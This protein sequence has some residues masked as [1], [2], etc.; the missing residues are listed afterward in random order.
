MPPIER[1]DVAIVGAGASGLAAAAALRRRGVDPVI[2][3]GDDRI[4]GTWARRYDRL[5]LHTAR[6]FSALPYHPLPRELPRY[7]TKDD[8]ARYL[9]RCAERLGLRVRL[10]QTVQRIRPAGDGADWL[11]DTARN[12]PWQA[13]VVVVATGKHRVPRIPRW[14]G[15]EDFGGTLVHSAHYRRGREFAGRRA[16]VVGIGNSGAEIAVDLVEAGAARVAV[17]VRTPPPITAR[18][19]LGI[20]VQVLGILLAPLPPGPIDRVGALLRRLSNG[21]L[22]AYGLE[23]EAWGPFTARR[24]PVID[25]GFVAELKAGR[26]A[27]RPGIDRFTE[28][29][30]TFTDGRPEP[31]DVVVAA[32]GFATGLD[33]LLA[34]PGVLDDRALPRQAA[35]GGSPHPGLFFIGFDETPRGGLFEA[36]REARRLARC[37]EHYLGGNHR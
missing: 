2:L 24:P 32:T 17:A 7:V 13:R 33:R 34:V 6:L 10:G 29:G 14:P 9:A 26:I 36:N 28:D 21:D 1:L 12:G 18:Q 16:L 4:G 22:R 23:P 37:V 31:F 8:Y 30:V 11:L 3:D 25:A 19:V 15:M 35:G 20:P 5:C 27:V